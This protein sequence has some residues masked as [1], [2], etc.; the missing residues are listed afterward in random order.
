VILWYIGQIFSCGDNITTRLLWQLTKTFPVITAVVRHSLV[1][2]PCWVSRNNSFGHWPGEITM[3]PA[4]L[5][6][7]H[8]K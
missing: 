3:W 7:G 2:T 8:L 1:I 5:T 6:N 4:Y